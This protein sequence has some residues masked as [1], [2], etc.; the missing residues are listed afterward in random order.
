MLL[1]FAVEPGVVEEILGA[2]EA[3]AVGEV[4]Q[5]RRHQRGGVSLVERL[6]DW[7]NQRSSLGKYDGRGRGMEVA[8]YESTQRKKPL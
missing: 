2:G 1:P 3:G 5:F 4:E 6:A 7:Q 8:T